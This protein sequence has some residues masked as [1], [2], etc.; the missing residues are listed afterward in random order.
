M[1]A[2]ADIGEGLW[3]Q[4]AEDYNEHFCLSIVIMITDTNHLFKALSLSNKGLGHW[5]QRWR[6]TRSRYSNRAV[7]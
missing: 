5:D 4:Y 7:T 3:G 1:I 2:G 6:Y